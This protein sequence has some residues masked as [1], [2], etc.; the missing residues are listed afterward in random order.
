MWAAKWITASNRRSANSAAAARDRQGRRPPARRPSTAQ[1]MARRQVVVDHD[2]WPASASSRVDVAADVAG[3]AGH[4]DRSARPSHAL[5]APPAERSG[6]HAP[7]HRAHVQSGVRAAP[8]GAEEAIGALLEDQAGQAA[9]PAGAGIDAD[10]IGADDG[11]GL[12]GVAVDDRPSRGRAW[13][14]GTARGSRADRPRVCWSSGTP[15]RT[16]AWTNSSRRSRSSARALAGNRRAGA[17]SVRAARP[18][19]AGSSAG[20]P[21]RAEPRRRSCAG[22]PRRRSAARSARS[23]DR[24]GSSAARRRDCRAD[25]PPERPAA[26]R[27]SEGRAPRGSPARGRR[28]RRRRR[29][30]CRCPG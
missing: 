19:A 15:G 21:R 4:Q 13:S 18:A 3:T 12:D 28:S 6:L 29:P 7:N 8:V 5:R 30:P 23:W 24:P 14:S 26:A 11:L 22:W 1:A 2:P 20:L 16:P 27:R 9:G 25:A 10:A 17:A